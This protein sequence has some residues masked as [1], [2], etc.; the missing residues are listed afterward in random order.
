VEHTFPSLLSWKS[1]LEKLKADVEQALSKV[2]EG[3]LSIGPGFK[4]KRVGRKNNNKKKKRRLRWVPKVK[5]PKAFDPFAAS[6]VCPEEGPSMALGCGGSEIIS[7]VSEL[8]GGLCPLSLPSSLS[9][10]ELQPP[11]PMRGTLLD[12]GAVVLKDGVGSSE[13]LGFSSVSPEISDRSVSASL[14]SQP[15]PNSGFAPSV[16]GMETNL[17]VIDSSM[18]AE[19]ELVVG[20]DPHPSDLVVAS[21]S[22][23][24]V[25]RWFLAPYP[26]SHLLG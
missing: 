11:R 5:K 4:P 26:I 25:F 23:P 9:A 16:L 20:S 6:A 3:L 13:L 24:S 15:E 12:F 18:H 1:Q 17:A 2:C 19:G 8:P 10:P 14:A 22:A 7:A 21:D